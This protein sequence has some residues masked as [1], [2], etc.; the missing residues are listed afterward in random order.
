MDKS[1]EN[2]DELSMASNLRAVSWLTA[3]SLHQVQILSCDL[4]E[5]VTWE[6]ADYAAPFWRLYRHDRLGA[7]ITVAGK[8]IP[9]RP[10]RLVLIPPNTHFSG[11]LRNPI[12]Q[13][14]IHFLVEPRLRVKPDTIFQFQISGTQAACCKEIVEQITRDTA[15]IRTS[16]LS[17]ILVSLALLE[18][19]AKD[20]APR[21]EDARITRAADSIAKRYPARIG[22]ATLARDARMHPAAFGRLFRRCTGHT[23]LAYLTNLRLEEACSMLHYDD[24]SLD[25]IAEKT[26]YGDRGYFTR[27]FS[28]NMNCSPARYRNL[29]NVSNR[30]RP[31]S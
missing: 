23:P 31:G 5:F 4:C 25:E 26:G 22:N 11:R 28:R 1:D 3:K 30:L 21:F 20:W 16:L 24:S 29:V 19:P 14:F 27:V 17:Q 13:L 12:R 7:E 18:L 10:G 6:C 2:G 15:S 9:I 8:P